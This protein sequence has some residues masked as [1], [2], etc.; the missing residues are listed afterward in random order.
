MSH[1]SL[2]VTRIGLGS[3]HCRLVRTRG[4]C[5]ITHVSL[6][7]FVKISCSLIVPV[8]ALM[9]PV[10]RINDLP[11]CVSRTNGGQPRLHVTRSG[12]SVRRSTRGLG[13]SRFLPRF[14]IKMSNDCDS[15]KCGFGTSLS[16]GCTM[17]TGI[18]VPLFR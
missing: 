14:C 13:R 18:D 1:G 10:R 11:T 2:L 4:G 8:S 3:T 6:G 7:S 12:V 9:S 17:C 15:P 16:P 5:R